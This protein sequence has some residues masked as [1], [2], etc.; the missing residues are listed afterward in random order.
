MGVD[1]AALGDIRGELANVF[2]VFD[3]SIA[4]LDVFQRN[5]VTDRY[6]GAC[7]QAEGGVVMGNAAKHVS[8]CGQ[9]LDYHD[10]DIVG[11]F[12]H[13]QVRYFIWNWVGH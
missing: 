6:V 11:L 2:A 3:R 7:G 13:Q 1:V 8:T 9:A 12:M 10:A 5:L 4:I